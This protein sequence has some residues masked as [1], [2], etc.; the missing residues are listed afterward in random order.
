[1]R[2]THELENSLQD[3]VSKLVDLPSWKEAFCHQ[4]SLGLVPAIWNPFGDRLLLPHPTAQA[5]GS[6]FPGQGSNSCWVHAVGLLTTGRPG[7]S[8]GLVIWDWRRHV[9]IPDSSKAFLDRSSAKSLSWDIPWSSLSAKAS[10][11]CSTPKVPKSNLCGN[12]RDLTDQGHGG[13]LKLS[14]KTLLSVFVCS[15]NLWCGVLFEN[16]GPTYREMIL[17][18]SLSC[19]NKTGRFPLTFGWVLTSGTAWEPGAGVCLG[20]PT[21]LV[22]HQPLLSLA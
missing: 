3:A 11:L 18:L 15:P 9:R 19:F 7:K 8:P 20:Y 12:C 2:F 6:W 17:L 16:I 1:M 22:K 5:G 10:H 14:T 13:G 21:Y 4:D